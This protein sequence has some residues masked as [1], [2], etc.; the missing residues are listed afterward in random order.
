MSP[1]P[2]C[3]SCGVTVTALHD[4]SLCACTDPT[5]LLPC[6]CP[7]PASAVRTLTE[8]LIEERS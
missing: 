8:R 7:A 6:G 1:A 5:V 4:G 2:V 3:T